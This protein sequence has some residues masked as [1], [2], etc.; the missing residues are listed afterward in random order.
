M[1]MDPEQ[2]RRRR[3]RRTAVILA[4]IALALYVGYIVMTIEAS[5]AGHGHA[6]PPPASAPR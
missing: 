5:R 3:V 6:G 1:A 4:L 2:E